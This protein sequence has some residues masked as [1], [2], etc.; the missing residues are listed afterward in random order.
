LIRMLRCNF[1]LSFTIMTMSSFGAGD[2][3]LKDNIR[4]SVYV[5]YIKYTCYQIVYQF[6][7]LY[8]Q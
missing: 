4:T 8:R 3:E 6:K 5:Y 7:I 2:T 1:F